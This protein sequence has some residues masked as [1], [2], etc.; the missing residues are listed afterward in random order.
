MIKSV[1]DFEYHIYIYI[2]I[3]IYVDDTLAAFDKGQDSLNFLNFLNNK[4]PNIA[5][6]IE[7]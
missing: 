1:F 3:Y 6:T 4:H 7:K 5:F 2:Y